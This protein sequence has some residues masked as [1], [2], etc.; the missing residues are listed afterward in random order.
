MSNV[1]RYY[2]IFLREGLQPNIMGLWPSL[3]FLASSAFEHHAVAQ[4]Y[5]TSRGCKFVKY[6]VKH[7]Y[8]YIF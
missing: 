4:D 2:L 3:T 7:C 8:T 6:E 5:I 1:Y